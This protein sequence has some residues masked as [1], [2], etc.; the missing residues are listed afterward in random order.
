MC[1]CVLDDLNESSDSEM[2]DRSTAHLAQM[3]I[4]DWLNFKLDRE[5]REACAAVNHGSSS[6]GKPRGNAL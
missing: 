2:E 5:V 3:K 4:D 6:G 1:V